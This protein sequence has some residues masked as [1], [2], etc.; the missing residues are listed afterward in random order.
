MA[1]DEEGYDESFDETLYGESLNSHIRRVDKLY[2]EYEGA[3]P[4][5]RSCPEIDKHI[6]DLEAEIAELE[7]GWDG[8]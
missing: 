8:G 2:D 7:A 5:N 6:A 4:Q 3:H 1:A